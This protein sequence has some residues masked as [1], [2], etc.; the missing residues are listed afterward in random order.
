MVPS[1][2]QRR[3]LSGSATNFFH[4]VENWDRL[5]RKALAMQKTLGANRH[6]PAEPAQ[7][8]PTTSGPV[9]VSNPLTDFAFG[10]SG[11]FTQSETS[12]AWCGTHV[13]VGFNDSGSV[14]ES[15]FATGAADLSF[16]GFALSTTAGTTYTDLGFLPSATINPFNFLLG[17][18]VVAC[19]S[20]RDFFYSSLFFTT[21]ITN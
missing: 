14:F 7:E 1:P 3:M 9:Q 2:E 13:V 19:T 6:P 4:V 16:N 5:E 20:E 12:T 17:D 8:V 21:T 11:G 18:P 15:L 10:P